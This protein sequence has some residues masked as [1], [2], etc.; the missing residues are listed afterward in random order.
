MP[1]TGGPENR[2]HLVHA[3]TVGIRFDHGGNR[4]LADMGCDSAVTT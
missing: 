1:G 3:K 2:R 4:G